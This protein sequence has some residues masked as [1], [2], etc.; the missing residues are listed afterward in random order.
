MSEACS[1]K[2]QKL[3]L[4][5]LLAPAVRDG[6]LRRRI[7][8]DSGE[9][10]HGELLRRLLARQ[11]VE[12]SVQAVPLGLCDG[13]GRPFEMAH[14]QVFRGGMR[15]LRRSG[16]Q[17]RFCVTCLA[18]RCD[19]GKTP[20]SASLRRQLL[21]KLP[22]QCKACHSK[23]RQQLRKVFACHI[24]NAEAKSAAAWAAKKAGRPITCKRCGYKLRGVTARTKASSGA[25]PA[26]PPP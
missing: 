26:A 4:G 14:E 17:R 18:K 12:F 7:R 13:C 23:R 11:E 15:G 22:V 3:R 8:T 10:T 24:C 16:A 21:M 19:C 2:L 1:G 5:G 25:P 6:K 9:L 20:L